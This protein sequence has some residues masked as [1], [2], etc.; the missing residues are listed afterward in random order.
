M[1]FAILMIAAAIAATIAVGMF[2]GGI[3]GALTFG[4]LLVLTYRA[5]THQSGPTRPMKRDKLN[6]F[7][8]PLSDD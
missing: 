4:A 2:A 1:I 7:Q 8:R 5:I 3:W 6:A